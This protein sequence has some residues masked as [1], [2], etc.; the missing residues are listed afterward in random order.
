MLE[1]HTK[2][3][4]LDFWSRSKEANNGAKQTYQKLIDEMANQKTLGRM[5]EH[6]HENTASLAFRFTQIAVGAI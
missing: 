1:A 4:S 3:Y 5:M 2:P 6:A